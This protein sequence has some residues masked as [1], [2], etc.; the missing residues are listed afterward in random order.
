M[1]LALLALAALVALVADDVVDG[2]VVVVVVVVVV[3]SRGFWGRVTPDLTLLSVFYI[4]KFYASCAM[5]VELCVDEKWSWAIAI[6]VIPEC[7]QIWHH[8]WSHYGP[9]TVPLGMLNET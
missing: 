5:A 6:F 8:R 1:L 3:D 9:V 2:C 4:P 7:H